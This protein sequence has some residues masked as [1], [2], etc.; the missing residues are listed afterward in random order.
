MAFTEDIAAFF[1]PRDFAEA[2]TYTPAGGSASSVNGH[3]DRAYAEALG[4]LAGN[5]PRFACASADVPAA[6]RGDG[7]VV[8]GASYR[9]ANVEPDGTGLVT[10]LT[11]QEQ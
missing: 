7:L 9:I 5:A 1:D 2:A 3:F 4:D 6:T 8:R 10:L 11:L